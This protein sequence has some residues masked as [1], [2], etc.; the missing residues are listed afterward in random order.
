[1]SLVPSP[2]SQDLARILIAA[3]QQ[4][5]GSLV[6]VQAAIA[7]DGA[8]RDARP[9]WDASS[10]RAGRYDWLPREKL[11]SGALALLDGVSPP[12]GSPRIATARTG[13]GLAE[14]PAG[15]V[16]PNIRLG[17]DPEA[18]P[19][20]RRAQA[21]PHV[22]RSFTTQGLLLA[23]FQEGRFSNG[24]AYSCGFGLSR[25]G[26]QTW[27]RSLIPG[28]VHTVEDGVFDRASDPVVAVGLDD[29]LLLNTL[30]LSGDPAAWLTA[31]VVNRSTD[32]GATFGDPIVVAESTSSQLFLDKNWM[33]ANSFAGTPTAGRIVV[34]LTRF[35]LSP[36]F[37]LTLSIVISHSDDGGLTWS[38]LR[39]V[40]GDNV[41]GS[42]PVFLPDGSLALAYWNFSGSQIETIGSADGGESF[43]APTVVATVTSYRDPVARSAEFLPSMTVDRTLGI[44]HLAWQ[45]KPDAPRILVARS[46]DQGRTWSTPV[47]VN[48]TPDGRGVF[49]PAI[50]VSPDGQ[51]VTVVFYDKRHDDGSGRWVDLYLAESFDGGTTWG[52]NVRVT[53]ESSDLEQAP[54][55]S[56]RRMLGDYQGIVPALNPDAPGVVVWVD[57]R[58]ETP[59]PYSAT[60]ERRQPASFP[61][62]QALAFADPDAEEARP[63]VD[64]EGDGLPNLV[65]YLAGT[66]PHRV[67]SRLLR[68]APAP[69][70]PEG[71]TW[72]VDLQAAVMDVEPVWLVGSDLR[73]WTPTNLPTQTGPAPEAASVRWS[74][75][76][77]ADPERT[78]FLRL[79]ARTK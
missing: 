13:V 35:N 58:G 51:H 63:E 4:D 59:D 62:W 38:D 16:G 67:D 2:A 79:G 73:L 43:S 56:G 29:L 7:S 25:D 54:L 11:S 14:N 55:T 42:Q 34:T 10:V 37:G 69:P 6:G 44:L 24:G 66:S 27:T 50:A 75:T 76:L 26:G 72:T 48:D 41:Q 52:P 36:V 45:A 57:T 32:G 61:V 3:D 5:H 9:R 19:G 28:L 31:V 53:T 68:S 46:R 21:E 12:T 20:D 18:L 74:V 1:M 78:G 70:S 49:N 22:A 39:P 64:G 17:D 23:A 40:T 47:P 33:A 30:G 71:V 8:K 60:F 15:P 77:A 65:E